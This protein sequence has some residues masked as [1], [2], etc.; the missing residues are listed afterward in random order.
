MDAAHL[1]YVSDMMD[2]PYPEGFPEDEYDEY[3]A[4]CALYEQDPLPFVQWVRTV[5]LAARWADAIAPD[6]DDDCWK[7]KF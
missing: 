7:E 6:L 2:T 3:V 4:E 1:R 5:D